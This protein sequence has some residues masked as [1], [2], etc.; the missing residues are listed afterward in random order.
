MTDQEA[1]LALA[2]QWTARAVRLRK[3]AGDV[4]TAY[5][6]DTVEAL[7]V[8]IEHCGAEALVSDRE[9]DVLLAAIGRMAPVAEARSHTRPV[10]MADVVRRV[11]LGAA[12]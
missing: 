7:R 12:I 2:R 8:R 3:E 1:N 9:L 5:E 10:T 4:L 6:A 11:R